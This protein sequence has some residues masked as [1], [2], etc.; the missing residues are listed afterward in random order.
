MRLYYAGGLD[1]SFPVNISSCLVLSDIVSRLFVSR[2][3]LQICGRQDIASALVAEH[4]SSVTNS[5]DLTT[6]SVGSLSTN[7][8]ATSTYILTDLCTL[9][10]A[11]RL[12]STFSVLHAN[13]FSLKA[14]WS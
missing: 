11:N 3:H 1:S 5:L 14:K 13:S 4:S 7:F 12:L 10:K 2:D 9:Y 8:Y 6:V